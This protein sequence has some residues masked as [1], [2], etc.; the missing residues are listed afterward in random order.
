MGEI[1]QSTTNADLQYVIDLARGAGKIVGD[2]FGKARRQTKTHAAA[3]A[4]AVTDADRASQRFIVAGLKQRWGDDGII[5]EE[6]DAGDAITNQKPRRGSRVW[7][8]DP[9]DGTNNFVAGLP[10]FAVCIGLLESG[11]PTLGVVFDVTRR[12]VYSAAQG[13]GA[14]L[15]SKRLC[16]LQSPLSDASVLMMT[17]NYASPRGQAPGYVTRWLS[18]TNWKVRMLGSA[19]LEAAQVAAGV[20]HSALTYNGKL[21]DLAAPA[22]LLL[23]AGALLTDLSGNPIF[24]FDLSNYAGQKVP[25]LAAAPQAQATLLEEIKNFP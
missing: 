9:L 5:G 1:K 10:D 12:Q 22:A 23:E 13:Q 11:I 8:I 7:V 18:Q 15:G 14:W 2:Y 20:A 6:N 3:Q 21:W 16:A 4:E 24:P 25:F 19:A 17:S